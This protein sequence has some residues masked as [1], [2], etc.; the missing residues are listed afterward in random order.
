MHH[1][2]YKNNK[3]YAEGVPLTE[4]AEAV[5]TPC[6]IYSQ[7]TLT[8]HFKVFD[9]AFSD[10]PHLTC[11]SVKA[12]SNIALLKLFASLGGGVDV[13]SG[14]ELFRALKAEVPPQKDC[15]FWCR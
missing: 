14:G 1:F 7:A 9:N 4:I 11:Y 6:Y 8:H 15:F 13:V 2:H 12:N 10:V 3:L 5:G